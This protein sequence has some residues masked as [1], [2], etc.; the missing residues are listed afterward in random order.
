MYVEEDR[1]GWCNL[2]FLAKE[3]AGVNTYFQL[4]SL[5]IL[6][7]TRRCYFNHRASMKD[8]SLHREEIVEISRSLT[9]PSCENATCQK[10]IG[11]SDMCPDS[12]QDVH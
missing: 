6:N 11:K 9:T 12:G 4:Y 5:Y 7:P 3:P 2:S 1:N 10:S 8:D